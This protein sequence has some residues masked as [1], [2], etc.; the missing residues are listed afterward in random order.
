VHSAAVGLLA[1]ERLHVG[2]PAERGLIQQ[3]DDRRLTRRDCV[4]LIHRD[5]TRGQ[6]EVRIVPDQDCQADREQILEFSGDY[7]R[8]VGAG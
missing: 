2:R 3:H 4:D 6:V 5:V 7:G 8:H 1:R